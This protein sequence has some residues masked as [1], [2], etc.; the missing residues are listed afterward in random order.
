LQEFRKLYIVKNEVEIEGIK[1]SKKNTFTVSAYDLSY[2][3]CNKSR[4][5]KDYG[6]TS[7]GYSLKGHTLNSARVIATDPSIIPTGSKVKLEFIEEKYKKYDGIYTAL[8]QGGLVKGKHIDLF[9]GDFKSNKPNIKTTSFGVTT[10]RVIILE[11]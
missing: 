11:D 8:D 3:S 5:N 2:Q 10:V 4:G 7:T 1:N 9:F 6:V